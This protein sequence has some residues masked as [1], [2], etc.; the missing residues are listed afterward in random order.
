[1]RHDLSASSPGSLLY[2]VPVNYQVNYQVNYLK[3]VSAT[4]I[5]G[6]TRPPATAPGQ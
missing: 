5:L 4:I 1:M 3:E 2:C 6:F